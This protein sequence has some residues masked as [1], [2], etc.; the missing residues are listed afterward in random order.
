MHFILLFKLTSFIQAKEN[1]GKF[2]E[3]AD[4][5]E[6][7]G[8]VDSSV[9]NYLKADRPDEA[10]RVGRD[11]GSSVAANDIAR[12][13]EQKGD[14]ETAMRFLVVSKFCDDALFLAFKTSKQEAYVDIVAAEYEV[15]PEEFKPGIRRIAN[16]FDELKDP[17]KAGRMYKIAGDSTKVIRKA[18][19]WA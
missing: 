17:F 9:R 6:Q 3:A 14:L 7:C 2:M 19:H 11:S 5:Y 15:I 4:A 1:E 18:M 13:F 16:Y 12:Y 10:I 8:D